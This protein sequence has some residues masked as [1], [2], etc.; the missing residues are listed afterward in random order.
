MLTAY[1]QSRRENASSHL[2]FES[3]S[4][5]KNWLYSSVSTKIDE[6]ARCNKKWLDW[7]NKSLCSV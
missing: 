7:I 1:S 3:V 2:N 6:D 5:D 4:E